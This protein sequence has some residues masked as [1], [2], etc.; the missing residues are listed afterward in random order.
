MDVEDLKTDPVSKS[1]LW[2]MEEK[3]I[4][5][6]PETTDDWKNNNLKEIRERLS[7]WQLE[8]FKKSYKK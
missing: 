7:G 8:G 5:K 2:I 1:M 4:W 6:D 3:K